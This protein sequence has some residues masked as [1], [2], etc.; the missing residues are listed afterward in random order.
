MKIG[1]NIPEGNIVDL[2]VTQEGRSASARVERWGL[3]HIARPARAGRV[4]A[5]PLAIAAAPQGALH[6]RQDGTTLDLRGQKA[7]G[8]FVTLLEDGRKLMVETTPRQQKDGFSAGEHYWLPVDPASNRMIFEPGRNHLTLHFS[9]RAGAWTLAMVAAE[10][11]VTTAT[12]TLA[13]LR[14]N[15]Q[16]GSQAKPLAE[17]VAIALLPGNQPSD[18][19]SLWLLFER[20]HSYTTLGTKR[21]MRGQSPL[22]PLLFGAWGTGA[23]PKTATEFNFAASTTEH[24]V[25]QDIHFEGRFAWLGGRGLICDGTLHNG[26][27]P[28]QNMDGVTFHDAKLL[29]IW[30]DAP[31]LKSD[32]TPFVFDDGDGLGLRWDAFNNRMSGVY[33]GNVQ[34]LFFDGVM[35][36]VCGYHPDYDHNQSAAMPHPPSMFSHGAY[37]SAGCRDVMARETIFS[38]GASKGFDLR[39][40][41]YAI[42]CLMI[43]NEIPAPSLGGNYS[44]AGAV[45]EYT[46]FLGN[47]VTVAGHKRIAGGTGYSTGAGAYN[48]G[49]DSLGREGVLIDNIIAHRSDPADP[50]DQ[51]KRPTAQ[52][53]YRNS[54][55]RPLFDDTIEYRWGNSGSIQGDQRTGGLDTAVLDQ[56][57]IQKFADQARATTGSKLPD[58]YGYMR[59][60][61]PAE[62]ARGVLDFFR[63]G[64][65][66]YVAPRNAAATASFQ[67]DPR[68]EGSRWDNR[69]N[70]TTGDVPGVAHDDT[71]NLFGHD[72]TFGNHVA[73][74]AALASDGGAL[75][76]VSGR[77]TIDASADA[78]TATVRNCG[79]LWVGTMAPGAVLNTDTAGRIVFT[80]AAS[81]HALTVAGV[82]TEILLGAD[83]SI[84]AGKRLDLRSP[85]S[86]VGWDGAGNAAL[87]IDGTLRMA[88]GMTIETSGWSPRMVPGSEFRCDASGF[89]GVVE[90]V[91]HIGRYPDRYHIHLRDL[92][93]TPVAGE[94][95]TGTPIRQSYSGS[96]DFDPDVDDHDDPQWN[97]TTIPTGTIN[98][99]VSVAMPRMAP[100]VSG[101]HGAGAPTVAAT[102]ALSGTLEL[103]L[104][105]ITAGTTPLIA[106]AITGTFA[107][108]T[109][110]GLAPNLNATVTVA[111]DGVTLTLAAGT[112]QV[113]LVTVPTEPPAPA[114]PRVSVTGGQITPFSR[115]GV[116]YVEIRFDQSG[117]FSVA[118]ALG[119]H[120]RAMAAGGGTGGRSERDSVMP[121]AGGA[122]GFTQVLDTALAAGNY[123]VTIGAGAPGY[124]TGVIG[125]ANGG[126][127]RLTGPG[128]DLTLTGGGSGGSYKIGAN[129]EIGT[130][131]GLPGGS[132][133]G[134]RATS[135]GGMAGG[136]GISGQGH[137]GGA[138]NGSAVS[139]AGGSGGAG[140]IGGNG[141]AAP[142]T[143]G[144][145]GAGVMLDWIATPRTVCAGERG[146]VGADKGASSPAREYGSGSRGAVNG[147]VG[148]GGDGFLFVVLRA[149]QAH[150]VAA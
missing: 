127:S 117:S 100:F 128:I 144:P 99:I 92:T 102:V 93:G 108:V 64:F 76:V 147:A 113:G 106:A 31:A 46:L 68:A 95:F 87:A 119:W 54:S 1:F 85:R 124:A 32:G 120:R 112:G 53:N 48:W 33:G 5:L 80:G 39:P 111:A 115:G 141:G 91:E 138:G 129:F 55:N 79:Q 35:F 7:G 4:N 27:T 104:T 36:D 71:V 81:G 114:L 38:R 65:G 139:S 88:A 101:I 14:A 121:G 40:G 77:L 123:I 62:V 110:T 82:Q 70:W 86:L 58:F 41:G 131:T 9:G 69:L 29:D 66:T 37:I 116:D 134:G 20:G 132:G 8:S 122:G 126:N 22:H 118:E 60:Q 98:S 3:A 133:G 51:A 6:S 84:A 52:S 16:Y 83:H 130:L 105:G 11:G 143:G 43:D 47:V 73:R 26:E 19:L 149:D 44:N 74:L 30:H 25:F 56:T 45:G 28:V 96:D 135:G 94:S 142:S 61:R 140:G 145:A 42:D 23:M 75:T 49:L 18:K 12:I 148:K 34:G 67:P 125:Q 150:V 107:G 72:V 146:L 2:T 57:T 137:Q 50:A 15:P 24:V 17:E 78:L 13:W 10:A 59:Q 63:Q 89:R 90:W 109:A 21:Y 97:P 103:D 136:A